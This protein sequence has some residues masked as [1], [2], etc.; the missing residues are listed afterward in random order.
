MQ[1]QWRCCVTNTVGIQPTGRRLS[2]RPG[3]FDL[4]PNSPGLPFNGLHPRN[5]CTGN[6]MDY[7][8]FTDPEGK[9]GWIGLGL[10]SLDTHSLLFWMRLTST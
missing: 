3:D 8:S 5:P 1:L 4:Q 10:Y 7:Y 2:P 9:E 6:Y